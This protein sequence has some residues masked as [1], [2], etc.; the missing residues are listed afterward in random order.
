MSE[1]AVIFGMQRCGSNYFLSACRRFDDLTVYGE[2]YH[3]DGVFPFQHTARNDD[4]VKDYDV[5]QRIAWAIKSQSGED[6]IELLS[7][8]DYDAPY[9]QERDDYIN[10]ALVQ[11]AHSFPV[12]YFKALEQSALTDRLILKIFPEHLSIFHMLLILHEIRPRV[13]LMDRNP[14]DSFISYKKLLKTEVPQDVD[15]S[16]LKIDFNKAEYFE[17]KAQLVSYFKAISDYCQ[18]EGIPTTIVSF[19]DIHRDEGQDK[20]DKVRMIVEGVFGSP[21]QIRPDADN[22]LL[23][24]KQ[25]KSESAA[26]KVINQVRLPHFPQKLIE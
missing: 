15:T 1:V 11:F 17:Y 2:M 8:W 13:I 18:D 7:D 6:E 23:F 9:S 20:L 3:Q 22:F 5:K 25:D 16:H 10:K 4:I 24:S 26:E 21:V 12:R 19:E 14:V